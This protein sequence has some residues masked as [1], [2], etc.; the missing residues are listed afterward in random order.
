[1]AYVDVAT[2]VADAALAARVKAA[3]VDVAFDVATNKAAND[4]TT[5]LATTVLRDPN[6]YATSMLFAVAVAKDA[7]ATVITTDA[8]LKALV[9]S[10]FAGFARR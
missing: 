9:L 6:L 8:Q 10:I 5:A 2:D 1:M 4:E 3:L 7:R